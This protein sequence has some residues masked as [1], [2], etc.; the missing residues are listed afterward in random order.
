MR[1]TKPTLLSPYSVAVSSD[2]PAQKAPS[3]IAGLVGAPGPIALELFYDLIFV[4]SV[5]VLSD[6]YSHH[7]TAQNLTWLIS[8]FAVIWLIW[9]QT[10]LLFNLDRAQNNLM[11][12][13]VLGQMLLIVLLSISAAD[14]LESHSKLVGPLLGLTLLLVS[15]M[16]AVSARGNPKMAG[17]TKIRI[18]YFVVAAV[19]LACSPLFGDNAYL[20]F[21]PLGFLIVLAP[22][23]RSDPL[24]GQ[25][26]QTHHLVERFGAFTVIMLGET[27]VKT[28]LTA[29]EYDMKGL[30]VI[31]LL[32]NFVI[33]FAI[34]WLYFSNAPSVGP[35][36]GRG[37]HN[38]WML[39]HLPLHLSIVG[40]A[41][42]AALATNS[43]GKDVPSSAALYLSLPLCGVLVSM[44]VLELLSGQAH[45]RRVAG[46]F[47]TAC[48]AVPVATIVTVVI[49]SNELRGL[50]ILLAALMVSTVIG[51]NSVRRKVATEAR[52]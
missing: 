45:S 49:S 18:R 7:P 16:L 10:S 21:W 19:L 23:L 50:S 13:L 30:S 25:T 9:M 4:A 31:S 39:T 43:F 29:T 34:W 37:G 3:S 22:S 17:Y 1:N 12:A 46:I 27:F 6:S 42:G 28:A 40:V 32:A 15:A 44:V 48:I 26:I 8:V 24:G 35:T 33:V 2:P 51:S 47:L 52:T 36:A 11:R 5:V 38:T 20:L 41:V 14:D